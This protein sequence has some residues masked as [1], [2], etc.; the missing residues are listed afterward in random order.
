MTWILVLVFVFLSGAASSLF[1]LFWFIWKQLIN[2]EILAREDL[3]KHR[4]EYLSSKSIREQKT[5]EFR[6][7]V[8]SEQEIGEK[9]VRAWVKLGFPFSSDSKQDVQEDSSATSTSKANITTVL[10]SKLLPWSFA[11]LKANMLFQFSDESTTSCIRVICLDG[12]SVTSEQQKPNGKPLWKNNNVIV[13]Q[14]KDRSLI[15]KSGE[16][17]FYLLFKTGK[18]FENW[19]FR[20]ERSA[21]L[22]ARKVRSDIVEDIKQRTFWTSLCNQL[23]NFD[24]H[25]N[26]HWVTAIACRIFWRIHDSDGFIDFITTKIEKKLAKVKKPN[27]VESI[28]VQNISMGPNLPVI[29]SVQLVSLSHDGELIVDV[30]FSYFGEFQLTLEIVLSIK[31]ILRVP[32]SL[33]VELTEL[34]GKAHLHFNAPPSNRFWIGFYEEPKCEISVDTE[35]GEKTKLKNLPKLANI[36]IYKIKSE[37]LESMVLPNMD[38]FPLPSPPKISSNNNNLKSSPSSKGNSTLQYPIHRSSSF[39]ESIVDQL[40]SEELESINKIRK[41]RSMGPL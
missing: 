35:I 2:T 11:V 4:R 29:H 22:H 14:H 7:K 40:T 19:Y 13:L 16:K 23:V 31:K 12:C 26:P 34:S 24:A 27:V 25:L 28:H 20:L 8:S 1:I 10:T 33:A 32:V 37:L 36:I 30:D 6:S 15:S 17:S 18:D 21:S 39:D 5:N 41:R 38:D 3:E 9:E